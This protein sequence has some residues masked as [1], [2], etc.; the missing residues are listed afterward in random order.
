M[1]DMR[2][3]LADI[4]D[5]EIQSDN[6]SCYTLAD[7]I[8]AALPSMVKPLVWYK[9]HISGWNGDWHTIP[10]HYTIRCADENGWKWTNGQGAVGYCYSDDAAKAAAQAHY[11]VASLEAFGLTHP[12]CQ[13]DDMTDIN[14]LKVSTRC[15]G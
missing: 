5:A 4:C 12:L 9:S 1:S 14:E 13:G 8:S 3:K 15:L 10:T 2:E 11:V 7:A 6:P